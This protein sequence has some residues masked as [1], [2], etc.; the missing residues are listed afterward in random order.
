ML[1]MK[2]V[3]RRIS[4]APMMDWTDT[5]DFVRRIMRFAVREIACLLNVSSLGSV[6]AMAGARA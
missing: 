2:H 1:E 6:W 4:C 5:S 3:D